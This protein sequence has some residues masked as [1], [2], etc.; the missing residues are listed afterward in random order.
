MSG[1]PT[2]VAVVEPQAG[3]TALLQLISRLS[4]D[5]SSDVSKLERLIALYERVQAQQARTAYYAALAELQ[6]ELP[7]IEEHGGIKDKLGD[8]Q[9]TYALWEDVQAA[10]KPVLAR[11]GF[12]LTFAIAHS[13]GKLAVTG[14]LSHRQGHVEETTMILPLDTTGSKNSVQA[15]GSSVSY[16]MRYTARALLNLTSRGLDDDGVAA[17][18]A[19]ISEGQLEA[20]RLLI[21]RAG[22]DE[23]RFCHFIKVDTLEQLPA[24]RY[25]QAEQLLQQKIVRD[26][27]VDRSREGC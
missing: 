5:P 10:I 17:G 21:E 19:F 20:L 24:R 6:P 26:G 4:T 15:H 3:E 9:S 7:E 11:H 12:A 22:A 27:E 2:Q 1:E 13:D 25:R 16:G 18:T 8:V 23:E 14:K